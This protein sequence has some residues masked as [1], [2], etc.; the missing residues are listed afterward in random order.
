MIRE[1]MRMYAETSTIFKREPK[2]S[3]PD[4]MSI[5]QIT[6]TSPLF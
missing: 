3:A 2:A 1:R 4:N 5:L 6:L